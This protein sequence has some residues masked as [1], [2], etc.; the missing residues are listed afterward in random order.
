MTP[1]L[2]LRRRPSLLLVLL[3]PLVASSLAPSRA[4]P[5]TY[6]SS[7]VT[8]VQSL[9][10]TGYLYFSFVY[11]IAEI[12]AIPAIPLT[13]SA[14]YLFG[15][16]PGTAVVLASALVAAS[17]SFQIGRTF[18]RGWVKSLVAENEQLQSL[19]AALEKAGF[20]V[21]LL[22][23]LSPAFPFALS[24]Y[25][26]GSTGVSFWS[27]FWATLLGFAPGTLAYVYSG[28]VA[29]EVAN[30]G[31]GGEEPSQIFGLLA[32]LVGA[33]A[34]VKVVGDAASE[35]VGVDGVEEE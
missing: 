22:L 17:V 34:V 5:T 30:V 21:I 8:S 33:A 16:L 31:G 24:N 10:P 7:I 23:R 28:T 15:T 35:A 20:K 9:G 12:L 13:A 14:G 32:G 1:I 27:Y 18:L 4:D 6:F 2:T 3:V 29:A 26:Y 25:L 11:V 19:D